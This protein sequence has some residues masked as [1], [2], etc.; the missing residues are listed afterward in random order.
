MQGSLLPGS[1]TSLML[2]LGGADRSV[3][4]LYEPSCLSTTPMPERWSVELLVRGV[5]ERTG[6][7]SLAVL[8]RE[9]VINRLRVLCSRRE[10]EGLEILMWPLIANVEAI[11]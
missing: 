7:S 3:M 11:L 4:T 5:G 1:M 2:W 10:V 8:Q 9:V 6:H